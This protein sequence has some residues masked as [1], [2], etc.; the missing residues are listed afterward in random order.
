MLRKSLNKITVS[1]W[2]GF[3]RKLME[4]L[5]ELFKIL[6]EGNNFKPVKREEFKFK[7]ITDL[8]FVGNVCKFKAKR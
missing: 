8:E 7:E 6:E 3:E 5:I 4:D 2:A 1:I